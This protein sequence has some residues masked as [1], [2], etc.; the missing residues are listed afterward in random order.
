[1]AAIR[2]IMSRP[3]LT[4]LAEIER[5]TRKN[6]KAD[7]AFRCHIKRLDIPAGELDAIVHRLNREISAKIDCQSCANCCKT[8]S[9]SLKPKDIER[10][11]AHLHL[12]KKVFTE[13]YLKK[14]PEDG[15]IIFKS[16]PCPFLS[17]NSCSVYPYRPETCRS[18]PHLQKNDFVFRLIQA[19]LNCSVCPIVYNVYQRLKEE[20]RSYNTFSRDFGNDWF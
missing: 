12:S 14:D 18:Y 17:D 9:P 4:D 8:S 20:L 15:E 1:M 19:F 7:W 5:L 2:K 16:T 3:I 11:A 10:L 6:E 13:K